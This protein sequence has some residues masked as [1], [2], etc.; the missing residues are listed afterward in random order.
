MPADGTAITETDTLPTGLTA[1]SLS[2]MGCTCAVATL[3]RTRIDVPDADGSYP[4]IS[5]T[6]D[7]A[8]SAPTRMTNTATVSGGGAADPSTAT[9]TTMVQR[10]SPKPTPNRGRRTTAA[11][12]RVT[13]VRIT[14]TGV[15]ITDTAPARGK[16]VGSTLAGPRSPVPGRQVAPPAPG[17]RG[18]HCLHP[19]FARLR[20][21]GRIGPGFH[22]SYR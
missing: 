5:L 12:A 7:I 11:P 9:A 2:G 22:D 13:N 3:T 6:V 15:R 4:P 19:A 18:P 21:G 20:P 17:G 8:G 14:A 1:G 10:A 16:P